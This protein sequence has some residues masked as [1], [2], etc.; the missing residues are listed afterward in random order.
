MPPERRD[1]LTTHRHDLMIAASAE[2][3]RR[4]EA[5]DECVLC[6]QPYNSGQDIEKEM[7]I[8]LKV[9]LMMLSKAGT[10]INGQSVVPERHF[11][12]GLLLAEFA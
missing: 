7:P 11:L 3:Q 8:T 12:L 1:S 4:D 5:E 2:S 10:V 6:Q 9:R